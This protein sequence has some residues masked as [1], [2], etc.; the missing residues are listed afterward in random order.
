MIIDYPQVPG[1]R[2]LM[3]HTGLTPAAARVEHGAPVHF[4]VRIDG[5]EAASLVQPNES[6]WTPL[7][8]D[9]SGFGPGPHRVRF[10]VWAADSGMRHFCFHAEVRR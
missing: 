8:V 3:I 10:Q 7:A 9:M 2:E 1:G 5:R 4:E 6:T